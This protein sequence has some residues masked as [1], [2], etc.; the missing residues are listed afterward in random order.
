MTRLL[1]ASIAL[2][3][4]TGYAAAKDA[5]ILRGNYSANV[6]AQAADVKARYGEFTGGHG[7]GGSVDGP[8]ATVQ[9]ENYAGK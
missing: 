8:Q 3:G 2:A 7:M 9:D 4:V 1:I 6:L 5:P